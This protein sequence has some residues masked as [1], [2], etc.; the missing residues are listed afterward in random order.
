MVVNPLRKFFST[1]MIQRIQTEYNVKF[2]CETVSKDRRGCWIDQPGALFYNEVK[3]PDG[4]NWMIVYHG[5][6]QGVIVITDGITA[7]EP[8]NRITGIINQDEVVVYSV[9]RHHYAVLDNGF[10][11]GG[12]DY[13]RYGDGGGLRLVELEIT[14]HGLAIVNSSP[15]GVKIHCP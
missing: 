10:I 14:P 15:S 13:V 3:H 1:E 9:F 4:S 7:V 5:A 12:R 6:E 8:D 2:V 11:D